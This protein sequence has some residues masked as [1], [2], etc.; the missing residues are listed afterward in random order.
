MSAEQRNTEFD[1]TLDDAWNAQD[2]VRH[3]VIGKVRG[4]FRLGQLGIVI[5]YD[6]EHLFGHV[7]VRIDAASI[8][9]NVEARDEDL[10]SARFF[11]VEGRGGSRIARNVW[12]VSGDSRL[13]EG[14]S[15][16]AHGRTKVG[17]T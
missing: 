9:T 11:D 16:D 1:Q 17:L 3:L 6:P 12:T 2:P 14:P 5:G 4:R 7:E 10:R 8:D 13:S 15:L